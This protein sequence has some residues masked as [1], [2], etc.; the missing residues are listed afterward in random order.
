V[1]LRRE[2]C[3]RLSRLECTLSA[4]LGDY[5]PPKH[6]RQWLSPTSRLKYNR[7]IFIHY[8]F[9]GF[10]FKF[11]PS[12]S[13][14]SIFTMLDFLPTPISSE[15]FH[16]PLIWFWYLMIFFSWSIRL[17]VNE[18]L[19]THIQVFMRVTT[20]GHGI[21]RHAAVSYY[22]DIDLNFWLV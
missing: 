7:Y 17:S 4:C 19:I 15:S 18:I 22:I 1:S 21:A 20:D 11:V 5:H 12:S 2:D 8:L 16:L 10:K 13:V 6:V 14:V 3:A 9:A